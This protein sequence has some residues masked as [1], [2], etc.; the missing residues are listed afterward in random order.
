MGLISRNHRALGVITLTVA[1]AVTGCANSQSAAESTPQSSSASAT[2][3]PSATP[4]P[5]A[6][7][8]TAPPVA[9]QPTATPP[10]TAIATASATEQPTLGKVSSFQ[11]GFPYA[12]GA[13]PEQWLSQTGW[14]ALKGQGAEILGDFAA[15]VERDIK[16]NDQTLVVTN[17]AGD[18]LYQSPSLGLQQPQ[19]V[20][21]ILDRV[22]QNGKEFLTFFQIGMP[23]QAG[24][25]GGAGTPIAQLIVVDETGTATVIEEDVSQYRPRSTEDGTRALAFTATDGSLEAQSGVAAGPDSLDFVRVLNAETAELEPIPELVGQRWLARIDGVDVYR[26]PG[27]TDPKTGEPVATAGTR[28]WSTT[29]YD[30]PSGSLTFGPTFMSTRKLDGTCEILDLHTG[31]PL[32]FE[33]AAQGCAYPISTQPTTGSASSPNGD[34]LLMHWQD[35]QG[36]SAQWVVNLKTGE[37]KRIDPASNFVPTS[38]SDAGDVY[39]RNTAGDKTGYLRFPDQMQPQFDAMKLDLPTAINSQGLGMFK[40]EDLPTYFAVPIK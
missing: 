13:L 28:D 39:G 14:Y 11:T 31:E 35:D 25:G 21:P 3:T 8:T 17:S 18:V 10:P 15:F 22:R 4:T 6:A 1:L 37:Q 9:M 5:S 16:T 34:L 27:S 26:S 24:T 30:H 2:T 29:F 33:G 12:T 7:I 32:T 38:I 19:A 23:A 20:E 40:Y 36:V